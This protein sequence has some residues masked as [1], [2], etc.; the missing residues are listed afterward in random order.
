MNKKIERV[1]KRAMVAGGLALVLGSQACE[2]NKATEQVPG[3]AIES[4]T[5]APAAERR[6]A[7]AGSES[8]A[9]GS[10]RDGADAG[11]SK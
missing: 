5:P 2:D 9:D 1:G 8:A 10:S 7:G 4:T 6:E 11:G 3:K